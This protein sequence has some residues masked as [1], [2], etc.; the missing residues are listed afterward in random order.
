MENLFK[1][2][3][4]KF[5][6]TFYSVILNSKTRPGSYSCIIWDYKTLK[7]T[8][9]YFYI[10]VDDISIPKPNYDLSLNARG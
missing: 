3:K 5:N 7:Q 1:N 2:L 10:Y 4:L 9:N 6:K 8:K